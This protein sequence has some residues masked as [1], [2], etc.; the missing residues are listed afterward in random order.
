MLQK[1]KTQLE[2]TI[3]INFL[4]YYYQFFNLLNIPHSKYFSFKF[5]R[6]N[7]ICL[8]YFTSK[9]YFLPKAFANTIKNAN[10][11]TLL[12]ARAPIFHKH[13]IKRKQ[14]TLLRFSNLCGKTTAGKHLN[15]DAIRTP[16]VE[17]I[18][19]YAEKQFH[20]SMRMSMTKSI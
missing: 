16:G 8:P 14:R 5:N 6:Y 1:G 7:K 4:I 9:H 20:K 13:T 17:L 18:N 19:V 2:I 12:S 10:F 3:I 11:Y 15:T